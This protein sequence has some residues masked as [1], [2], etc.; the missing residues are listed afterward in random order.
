MGVQYCGRS[1][2]T[3]GKPQSPGFLLIR[4]IDTAPS[5][6][7]EHQ[8]SRCADPREVQRA[9]TAILQSPPFRSTKQMQK[10]LQF[11]VSETLA[12][13]SDLL[14]ERNIGAH[15]F[16]KRPDYDTNSD[17]TVRLRVAE[18]RKRL[19]LYYQGA[20]DE[21]VLINIPSGSFRAVFEWSGK[22]SLPVPADPI[23]EPE[24][25][26]PSLEPIVLP[27][28]SGIVE[29]TAKPSR[30]RFR[31]RRWWALIAVALVILT[32]GM[33]R[34]SR[35]SEERAFNKFW[36]PVLENSRTVLIGIGNNPI[37]E[38][39]NA[40]EDDYYKSH[41][42]TRFQEMGLHSYLPLSPGE[43][44]DSK[45]LR[46]A[47]NTYLTIGD[48]GAL[49]DI[50]YILAQQHIKLDIRF[51]N[52]LTYGDLRQN[53][54]ILIGAHNNI[55]TLNMTED[56]R[57][58][59]QGHSTIVDRFSPQN[60]WT[61]N[62]DRSETYAIAARLLNAWNGKVVVVIG[63]VGYAATRAAGDFIVDPQSILKM[64]KS[65][66]KDWEKKNVEIVLHTSVKNQVPGPA[67]IVAA[68][69]W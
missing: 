54:T 9:L 37:Y 17:P 34:Y 47:V 57:F 25:L 32:L 14:K 51:V 49:S 3:V 64:A 16:D 15:L 46:P 27:A 39:S 59:F 53:P 13:R 36:S 6:S 45:Y 26:P 35:S 55:W 50:E 5:S 60:Q 23:R 61:A 33:L 58:G 8:E 7:D 11:I 29:L 56:L 67:E 38:L 2:T 66:P 24:P 1:L 40:G 68:Y 12:G 20:R 4:A 44:I 43:S 62:A 63:G 65:L 18:L 22:H 52:D 19:A 30:T 48:V 41:P 42:R 28:G 69:C 10:L 31:W 21:T